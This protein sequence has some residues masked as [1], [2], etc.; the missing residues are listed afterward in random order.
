MA[1]HDIY[2]AS[3]RTSVAPL[4]QFE[5]VPLS[6][7]YENLARQ[8]HI[9]YLLDPQIN[10]GY[11]EPVVTRRWEKITATYAFLDICTNFGFKVFRDPE[12][13][14]ILIRNTNH[15]ANFVTPDF[16][17][18]DTNIVPLIEF[19]SVRL[20]IVL[21]NLAEQTGLKCI[22]SPQIDPWQL[23]F[24]PQINIS[25]ENLTAKQALAALCENYDLNIIKYPESGIIRVEPAD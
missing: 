16:Y 11:P 18:N 8:D 21:K 1:P 19:R 5:D 17:G 3:Y 24:E 25:W 13:S 22:F 15:P 10:F 4:I 9:E 23:G 12:T 6:I 14:I 20:S 2:G 7:A